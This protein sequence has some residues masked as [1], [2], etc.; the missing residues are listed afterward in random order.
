ML[1][2]SILQIIFVNA[3]H[4]LLRPG[5]ASNRVE[6][7]HSRL[8]LPSHQSKG[9]VLKCHL[10]TCCPIKR[11]ATA[12]CIA[13]YFSCVHAWRTSF[14]SMLVSYAYTRA[15]DTVELRRSAVTIKTLEPGPEY[16]W[17][18]LIL[19]THTH[20]HT[21]TI[22]PRTTQPH[23][24]TTLLNK[25][26]CVGLTCSLSIVEDQVTDN[27]TSYVSLKNANSYTKL[28]F[29]RLI[30]N[31]CLARVNPAQFIK[32]PSHNKKYNKYPHQSQEMTMTT[33]FFFATS[34]EILAPPTKFQYLKKVK[35]KSPWQ[36]E[37]VHSKR[38][39]SLTSTDSNNWHK[40]LFD[41]TTN[42][43][44]HQ[45][46]LARPCPRCKI[47]PKIKKLPWHL[48]IVKPSPLDAIHPTWCASSRVNLEFPDTTP[49]ARNALCLTGMQVHVLL[50][51]VLV[52]LSAI[53]LHRILCHMWPVM[54]TCTASCS[55]RSSWVHI[56]SRPPPFARRRCF[57]S[58]LP[59]FQHF[60]NGLACRFARG[61][62]C[63]LA[64]PVILQIIDLE[65]WKKNAKIK[66]TQKSQECDSKPPCRHINNHA[67]IRKH[68]HS[69][70]WSWNCCPCCFN[71][72]SA[73]CIRSKAS[74]LY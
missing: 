31:I 25:F 38:R 20:T 51:F 10:V 58:L 16:H 72:S 26:T 71:A 64:L 30:Q 60:F 70:K 19:H 13:K 22:E 18:C 53:F 69:T 11:H 9:Y 59:L 1:C 68:L 46:K 3:W 5:Q 61:T 17:Q 67:S 32:E 35:M 29:T 57:L 21:H 73:R 45:S 55:G 6:E 34:A 65:K 56:R 48:L 66:K 50:N 2:N 41:S 52:T 54:A 23:T 4:V 74:F 43:T 14:A 15:N 24:T 33:P 44:P 63:I 27:S 28:Q 8:G 42:G 62:T 47:R 12:L 49:H 39:E 37:H 40:Q 36:A 7:L